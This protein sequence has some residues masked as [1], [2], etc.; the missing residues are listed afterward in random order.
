MD[1]TATLDRLFDRCKQGERRAQEQLYHLLASKMLGVCMRYAKSTFEAEDMLQAGFVKV[2][3]SIQGF[4]G[5]G[6]AE[7]W[8][9]RVIVNT[10]ISTYRQ[11][12]RLETEPW[13]ETHDAGHSYELQ[14]LEYEDLLRLVRALPDGYRMVFNLYAIEGYS[15]KEIAEMLHISEGASK[16]QLSRARKWLQDKLLKVEGGNV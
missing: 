1:Q 16:S 3:S 4:R 2:F 14:H 7:G 10:A 15:H 12:L 6:S 8:V 5:E 13:Q 9:R 11:N